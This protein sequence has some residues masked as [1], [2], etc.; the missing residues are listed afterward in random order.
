MSDELPPGSFSLEDDTEV[1]SAPV[2]AEPAIEPAIEEP[3]PEGTVEIPTGKVV[4][5]QALQA[6]RGK[7]KEAKAEAE[8]IKAELEAARQKVQ[9]YA[10]L[11]Q[12]LK[13]AM[14]YI[15]ETR[16]RMTEKPQAE[17]PAG[18]LA[19]QEAVEYAKDMDLYKADGTPDVERAQRLAARQ[20][21][22][23]AKQAQRLVAPFEAQNAQQQ[24]Q[25][26]FTEVS[27]MKDS[28]GRTVDPAA[29]KQIWSS[30]PPELAAQPQV[31]SV[32]YFAAK[33]YAEH[34]SKGAREV[35]PAPVVSE[36]L[37]GS[38]PESA[39]LSD[40]E[41]RAIAAAGIKPADYRKQVSG[42][43]PGHM[44]VLE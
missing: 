22:I 34:H 17:A 1:V 37:G 19:P 4:P 12:K 40:V 25:R 30:V 31:A 32:L 8:A 2:T 9:E 28:Q 39:A 13:E 38:K 44:N 27:T 29:L 35:A 10:T 41:L 43:K 26:M 20:E 6:E 3:E 18:P 33:G 11:E 14:P 23:A 36:S 21:A 16:R 42:Y 5:L 15:E 7:A 24:A